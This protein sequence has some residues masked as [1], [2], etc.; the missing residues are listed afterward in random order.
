MDGSEF[1][2]V[3]VKTLTHLSSILYCIMLVDAN[4][5]LA[6]IMNEPEKSSI[7]EKTSNTAIVSPKI[8]PHEIGNALIAMW[9][10]GRIAPD[11]LQK[12]YSLFQRSQVQLVEVDI[13]HA[14]EISR[15]YNIY[16]YD[17]Y[18]LETAMRL[19]LSLMTLDRKIIHVARELNIQ[20]EIIE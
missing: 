3:P 8:L 15:V 1:K 17:A 5:F 20:L 11:L 12:Y 13:M 14:L 19:K 18:Y 7:I 2:V 9:K 16:A 4:I 10:R 6:V